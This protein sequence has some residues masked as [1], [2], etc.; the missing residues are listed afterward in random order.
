MP[1]ITPANKT[2]FASILASEGNLQVR[3][4]LEQWLATH[5][6]NTS[7]A[8]TASHIVDLANHS[9]QKAALLAWVASLT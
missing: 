5:T 2:T 7:Y 9:T 3:T 1:T 6:A 4:K 8:P